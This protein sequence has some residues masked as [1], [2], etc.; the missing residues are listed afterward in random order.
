ME[1]NYKLAKWLSGEMTEDEL[2]AFQAEPDFAIYDKIK[3]HSAELETPTFDEQ[4]V[5]SKIIATPKKETKT[6]SL[7]QHWIFRVA[8]VLVIGLGLFFGVRNF[9]TNTQIAE[10]GTQN[11]FLLPDNSEV[12]LN[13]GSEIEYKKWNWDNNRT[14]NLEGEAYFKVAKGKKFEVNTS[15]G[16]VTVLGTQFN[17][18]QREN[19]FDVTCYE[20]KVKVNYKDQELIITKGM[21]IAFKNGKAIAIPESTVQGPEWLNNEM[22]FYQEDLKSILDEFERHFNV[23]LTL[24]SNDNSQLFTGTIP[25]EN[26]EIALQILST[27][28]HLKP[29][30]VSKNEFILT[31]VDAQK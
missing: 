29:T 24:K 23:T 1:E 17:V 15:L 3:K 28:Y 21:S 4:L 6:I 5:L 20:G 19:R 2:A 8:A 13:S 31:A 9:A 12:V 26:L 14:L 7:T 16:K 25:S 27:T 22:V 11:T 18:K 10:N 30:K